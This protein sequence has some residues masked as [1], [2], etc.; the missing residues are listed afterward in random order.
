MNMNKAYYSQGWTLVE[1]M[2]TVAVIGL[3]AGIAVPTY[4][5]YILTSQNGA[6]RANAE[7]LAVFQEA[8]FYENGGT[9]VA[10]IYDVSTSTDTLTAPLEWV[11][12]GDRDI[13]R[14]VVTTGSCTAPVTQCYTI[15]VSMIADPTITQTITRP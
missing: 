14:Y 2:I 3:L 9:Y 15:T 8:Y 1:L 5:D 7:Q 11:P 10:G 4:N 13:F 6:A 12:S